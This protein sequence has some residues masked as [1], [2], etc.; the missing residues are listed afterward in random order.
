MF[1]IVDPETRV[2]EAE[3]LVKVLGWRLVACLLLTP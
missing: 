1:R 2:R 3:D